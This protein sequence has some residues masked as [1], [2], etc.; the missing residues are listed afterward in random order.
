MLSFV[1]VYTVDNTVDRAADEM[2]GQS[3]LL[4][5]DQ[6]FDLRNVQVSD[7]LFGLKDVELRSTGEYFLKFELGNRDVGG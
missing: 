4:L 5:R 1:F 6:R 7:L 3:R 2:I